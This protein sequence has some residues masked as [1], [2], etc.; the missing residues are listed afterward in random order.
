M[1]K[2]LVEIKSDGMF[3]GDCH[4]VNFY[5]CMLFDQTL[6]IGSYEGNDGTRIGGLI[7]AMVCFEAQKAAGDLEA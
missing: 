4:C 7:R 2:I 5:R 6:S 1:A 3:C